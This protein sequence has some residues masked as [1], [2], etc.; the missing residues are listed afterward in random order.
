MQNNSSTNGGNPMANAIWTYFQDRKKD[1]NNAFIGLYHQFVKNDISYFYVHNSN[2]YT[3]LFKHE[4][5]LSSDNESNDESKETLPKVI[6]SP[7]TRSLRNEL[8][9]QEIKFHMPHDYNNI[10]D[11]EEMDLEVVEELKLL[12]KN[13]QET[14]GSRGQ[15]RLIRKVSKNGS[16]NV[17]QGA[18]STIHVKGDWEVNGFFQF[19]LNVDLGKFIYNSN[20][21]GVNANDVPLLLSSKP[22]QNST[23]KTL[24]ILRCKH[25]QRNDQKMYYSLD[26]KGFIMPHMVPKLTSLFS[27]NSDDR[28]ADGGG[29]NTSNKKNRRHNDDPLLDVE[30]LVLENTRTFNFN[31]SHNNDEINEKYNYDEI[32]G[33]QL[34]LN[35]GYINKMKVFQKKIVT[36]NGGNNSS[37]NRLAIDDLVVL[38]D[39]RYSLPSSKM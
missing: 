18:T 2:T 37:M 38:N 5:I 4:K 32:K 24:E 19:L 16:N 8:R 27:F 3:I 10:D 30:Y 34:R 22:F 35:Y 23:L 36:T 17:I 11:Q 28:D 6:I 14:S 39:V 1:W 25:L 31:D 20:S 9:R 26:L 29:G 12:Q 21:G 33:N 13:V 15:T 7:S